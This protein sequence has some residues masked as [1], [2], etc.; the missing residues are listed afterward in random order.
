MSQTGCPI[1]DVPDGTSCPI[2]ESDKGGGRALPG[3]PLCMSYCSY[4]MQT[5]YVKSFLKASFN[6]NELNFAR[7]HFT[8]TQPY[9]MIIRMGNL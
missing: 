9:I 1:W 4:S 6:E 5:M 2:Y 7:S 8:L 3:H